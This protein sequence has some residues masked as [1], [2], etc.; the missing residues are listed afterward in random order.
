MLNAEA[1]WRGIE[2]RATREQVGPTCF[3]IA[4]TAAVHALRG[5]SDRAVVLRDEAYAFMAAVSGPPEHWRRNQH[6]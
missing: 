6:Y 3:E 4:L 1:T 5:Q 2:Q